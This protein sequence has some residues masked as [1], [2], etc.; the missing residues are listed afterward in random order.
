MNESKPIVVLM[1]AA[2]HDE[3]AGIAEM[4]VKARLVACVQILPEMRSVYLWKDEVQR[5]PEVLIVAKTLSSHFE[6]LE[7]EVRAMH[8]YETPE[9]IALPIEQGSQPYLEW[10]ARS[11]SS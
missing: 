2:S 7:R 10:L 3:A 4:L 6:R 8:S 11:C 5:E 1:T 9:I